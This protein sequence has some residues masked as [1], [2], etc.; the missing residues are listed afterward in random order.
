MAGRAQAKKPNGSKSVKAKTGSKTPGSNAGTKKPAAGKAR[1]VKKAS[2]N[3]RK[4]SRAR[5]RSSKAQ[6]EP[7]ARVSKDS[8][9]QAEAQA[10]MQKT[11]DL[12]KLRAF[13]KAQKKSKEL[14]DKTRKSGVKGKK[15]LA[16]TPRKGKTYTIDLRVHTPGTIGYF[17]TGGIDT[18]EAL[19][20]LAGVKKLDL[21]AITDYYNAD[22][23]DVVAKCA[24]KTKLT[25]V[26]GIDLCCQI[27]ACR[28]VYVTA[29]FPETYTSEKLSVVLEE[30]DVPEAAR[31]REDYT[32]P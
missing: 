7:T 31:G 14:A 24:Q 3:A 16:K 19:V 28:E 8:T 26:P 32:M 17:S 6:V 15:F 27:G 29:L 21:I 9:S 2:A 30:L 23:V 11:P 22:Y 10:E 13:Q 18:G 20:R 12:A 4:T 1:S 25:V 5:R